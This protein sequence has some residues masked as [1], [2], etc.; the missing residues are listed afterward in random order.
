MVE[1]TSLASVN[2]CGCAGAASSLTLGFAIPGCMLD[3][4]TRQKASLPKHEDSWCNLLLA[5]H[6]VV[7][8]RCHSSICAAQVG[9]RIIV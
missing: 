7:V 6:E 4:H 1:A 8:G 5:L 3:E 2:R 9:V